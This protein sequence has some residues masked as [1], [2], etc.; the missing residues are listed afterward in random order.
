MRYGS[1]EMERTKSFRRNAELER[2]L[3]TLNDSLSAAEQRLLEQAQDLGKD[4]PIVFIV[5]PLRSGTTLFMQWL[6]NTGVVAYPTN[7]LSRFYGAP[8]IGAQIQ[9]LLTDPRYDFRNELADFDTSISFRSEN[10]KT[11][12]TLEPNEF[13][14]FWR[15]FLPF[16]DLDWMPDRDLDRVVDKHML[17][18]ELTA[19]S[20]VFAKPFALKA[21]ILNYN[22]PF[23]NDIFEK[24]LFV[25]LKRDYVSNVASV[26]DARERQLGGREHWYSFKI[27]EYPQLKELPPLAQAAG[28]VVHINNAVAL[29]IDSIDESRAMLVQ[30]EEFCEDP[31][32]TFQELVRKLGLSEADTSYI[33]PD[34]FDISRNADIAERKAIESALSMFSND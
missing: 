27:R 6:A 7:L 28:Q 3:T 12:G 23:L 18:T 26:L 13:W 20:R 34:R 25:R 1:E 29:G 19:L 33:G 10:G 11:A 14:Y 15:R 31:R 5:G 17:L 22:I 24:A 21:L 32:R 8:V 30:Y 4:H 9:L 2:L 16:R